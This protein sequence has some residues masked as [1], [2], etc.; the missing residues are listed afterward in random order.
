MHGDAGQA[1]S[2]PPMSADQRCSCMHAVV[3]VLPSSYYCIAA[4]SSCSVVAF[5]AGI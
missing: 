1:A 2:A 4:D 3:A 5:A